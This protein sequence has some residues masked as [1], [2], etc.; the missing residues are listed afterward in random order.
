M[1]TEIFGYVME[2]LF[3]SGATDV[4]WVPAY[5]KKNRPGTMI[6][7]LCDMEARDRVVNTLLTETTTLGVR[8]YEIERLTLRRELV[9]R[10]TSLGEIKVK[11][12]HRPSGRDYYA[13]EYEV[14]RKIAIQRGLPLK[15]VYEIIIK[16]LNYLGG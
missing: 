6:Q 15:N 12:V 2:K 7:V 5:M 1:N 16:E 14:C 11:K 10:R 8:F 9:S 4:Y 3:E 13:P